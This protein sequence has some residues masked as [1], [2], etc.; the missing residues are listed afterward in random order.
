[1]STVS[2]P[3][4]KVNY[5]TPEQSLDILSEPQLFAA[6]PLDNLSE[7]PGYISTRK[8]PLYII[9]FK[10]FKMLFKVFEVKEG[11]HECHVACPKDSI[12]AS[13]ALTLASMQWFFKEAYPE[14]KG[15]ITSCPEGK[16]ANMCRKIGF[17]EVRKENDLVYFMAVSSFLK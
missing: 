6:L 9:T 2:K 7:L 10:S 17:K 13:R 14:A 12:R 5:A 4:F 8:I 3:T 15:L 16:I 1:M 11:I